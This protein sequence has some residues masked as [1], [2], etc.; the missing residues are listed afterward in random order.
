M[1][2]SDEARAVRVTPA[3]DLERLRRDA[4]P[5]HDP[6]G[7]AYLDALAKRWNASSPAVQQVLGRRWGLA[8]SLIGERARKAKAARRAQS[9][10]LAALTPSEQADVGA[11]KLAA[12]ASDMRRAALPASAAPDD[13]P[14]LRSAIR[15]HEM[16]ERLG[17]EQALEEAFDRAPENA[18]PLNPHMLVLKSLRQMQGISPAYLQRFISQTE[19][20]LWLTE[21]QTSARAGTTKGRS[22][23]AARNTRR[24]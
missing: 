17:S 14:Q 3:E 9:G 19:G 18:G 1:T 12:L 8:V 21:V 7:W 4:V 16:W 5:L 11:G 22:A 24:R 13:L 6:L 20:L 2:E 15:F 10:A 23:P